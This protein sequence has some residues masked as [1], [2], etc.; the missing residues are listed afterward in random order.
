MD[1]PC[2]GRTG[3]GEVEV[4]GGAKVARVEAEQ[5]HDLICSLRGPKQ[6]L[7]V[8][9]PQIVAEEID[10]RALGFVHL[11]RALV[12][13]ALHLGFQVC[14][15][16]LLFRSCV[17]NA[18]RI[19]VSIRRA[20]VGRCDVLDRWSLLQ[21]PTMLLRQ[22]ITGCGGEKA[23]K[24]N[25]NQIAILILGPAADIEGRQV[26]CH[27]HR[28]RLHNVWPFYSGATVLDRWG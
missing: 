18:Q 19:M 17:S 14:A 9:Q 8:V 7:I 5:G 22:E 26:S 24:S 20:C 27:L 12:R 2:T 6:N 15:M 1:V 11:A 4:V 10:Y 23:K 21:I 16:V 28:S 25:K 13:L 3:L